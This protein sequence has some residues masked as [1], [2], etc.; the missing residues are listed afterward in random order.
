MG[1]TDIISMKEQEDSDLK[2]ERFIERIRSHITVGERLPFRADDPFL[3]R[4]LEEACKTF[5]EAPIPE[6]LLKRID[7]K[8]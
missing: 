7:Q 6:W 8:D 2:W 3:V 4:K 5:E 1:T